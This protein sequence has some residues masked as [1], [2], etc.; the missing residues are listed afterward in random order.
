MF[1]IHTHDA[2]CAESRVYSEVGDAASNVF[3]PICTGVVAVQYIS[4]QALLVFI[5]YLYRRCW[6]SLHIC[7]G[8]VTQA[9]S[10]FNA[11][12]LHTKLFQ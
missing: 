11:V 3:M 5:T 1:L 6:C 2:G 8:P 12:I 4:V 10:S 7:T 9:V